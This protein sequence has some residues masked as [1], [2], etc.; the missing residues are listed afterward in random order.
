MGGG[1]EQE[2]GSTDPSGGRGKGVGSRSEGK[3]LQQPVDRK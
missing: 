1:R 3:E 2:G